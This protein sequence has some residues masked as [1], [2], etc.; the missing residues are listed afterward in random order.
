MK[1]GCTYFITDA[2]LGAGADSLQRERELVQFL[3]S[4]EGDCERL[5]LLGDM[6]EFWFSYRYVVPKG[7]VRLLG[8]LADMVDKGIEVHYFIG[9]HDMWLFDY[10]EQEIGLTMHPDAC[11]MELNGKRFHI[12]HGDGLGYRQTQNQHEKH[13]IHLKRLFRNHL[14]QR[15]FAWI[16]PRLGMWVALKWSAASRKGH[17]EKFNHYLG[18]ECEGIVLHCHEQLRRQPYDHFVFGHR[19]LALQMKIQEESRPAALY[20]NVGDWIE[21]R[22]YARFD[23]EQVALHQYHPPV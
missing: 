10:L 15:L 18:D 23:G 6:F 2:H 9:N 22:D 4:I 21:H 19:H 5:V 20:T 7:H 8:K 1:S 11:D 16:P 17:G 13:Y 12:G 14:C 3:S